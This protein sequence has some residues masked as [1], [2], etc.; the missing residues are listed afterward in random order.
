MLRPTPPHRPAAAPILDANLALLS[1]HG[2][3]TFRRRLHHMSHLLAAPRQL[4]MLEARTLVL[5]VAIP[6]RA[7]HR[8]C[9]L[10]HSPVEGLP[11]ISPA[12]VADHSQGTGLPGGFGVAR[13]A[14]QLRGRHSDLSA[15]AT[16]LEL[17]PTH[18]VVAVNSLCEPI[19]LRRR[20]ALQLEAVAQQARRGLGPHVLPSGQALCILRP[21]ARAVEHND[22]HKPFDEAGEPFL[23]R[24]HPRNLALAF[25][26]LRLHLILPAD[27][28]VEVL[29][30]AQVLLQQH[31]HS[32][33][34]CGVVLLVSLPDELRVGLP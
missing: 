7:G 25:R 2:I 34:L 22:A 1:R 11:P 4:P 27:V 28:D 14:L 5:V 6:D 29:L 30:L 12:A 20:E 19:N 21:E 16:L 33:Q 10:D 24:E 32:L 31:I 26:V 9:E 23:R 13:S 17:P 18:T 15:C 3:G 8:A